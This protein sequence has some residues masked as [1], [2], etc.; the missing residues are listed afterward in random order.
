[1]CGCEHGSVQDPRIVKIDDF[2]Y[3]TFAFRPYAWSS[4]PTGLGVPESHQS[5]F[6]GFSGQDVDNQSQSGIA[7]STDRINWKIAGWVNPKTIDDRNV[8]LF[9]ERIN[10]KFAVLRRPSGFVNTQ[11]QH[12][13]KAPAVQISYS[14]DLKTWS[15][16]Q[17]VIRPK[18]KWEDNRIGGSTPPIKTEH[19]WLVFYHGVENAYPPTKRVIY[20]MNAMILDL[21]DPTKVLARC[22]KP[23][24][25]PTEY[26][27]KFGL[28]IPNVVF[29][30]AAVVK[31]GEIYIYY[32]V[33]DTA[34]ALAT[35]SL[36]DLINH[37]MQC[38]NP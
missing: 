31:D 25:E 13:D 17:V 28:Y 10:G 4:Y 23:I 29:P 6:P 35:V 22:P 20:R 8:I 3:I 30:T 32:G 27:E 33:C 37:V 1:M 12:T 2:Y 9:P 11:A 21:E 24:L 36:D 34:I 16:P 26:Y 18:F 7:V 15:E 14:D 38:Q 5:D 19:G